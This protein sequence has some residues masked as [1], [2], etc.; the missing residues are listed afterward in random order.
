MRS[1]S[2]GERT[3]LCQ[4]E[5]PMGQYGVARHI[6]VCSNGN[7]VVML[8]IRR[9]RYFAIDE[10]K[11]ALLKTLVQGWPTQSS[12]LDP[13]ETEP[14][15]AL[16]N[17]LLQ[18]GMLT[19]T[20]EQGK[21]ATPVRAQLPTIE[22]NDDCDTRNSST[23]VGDIFAFALAVMSAK[24][25]LRFHSFERVIRRVQQRK[26]GH[27][28]HMRSVDVERARELA[29]TFQRLRVFLFSAKKQCLYDSL[30]LL[31][32]LASH[33]IFPSWVFG[34]QAN[35]FSAHCWVQCN[36]VVFNDSVENVSGY[37]PIMVV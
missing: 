20:L 25:A 11:A 29:E 23:R 21:D 27:A 14:A 12:C 2:E 37:T 13:V 22:L 24:F 7:Y 3:V 15:I 1:R 36:D 10:S 4:D 35:P 31:E 26:K 16:A 34:V 5:Q 19:H 33:D 32:F 18:Q 8:D 30:A 6:F 17:V 9:D 28:D